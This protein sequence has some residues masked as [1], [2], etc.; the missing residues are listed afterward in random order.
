MG[1]GFGA[2]AFV[3]PATSSSRALSTSS[4]PPRTSSTTLSCLWRRAL[5]TPAIGDSDARI[6]DGRTMEDWLTSDMAES[7]DKDELA[8]LIEHVHTRVL[9]E[10]RRRKEIEAELGTVKEVRVEAG[11]LEPRR[12]RSAG[13]ALAARRPT[14]A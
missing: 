11:D 7:L 4:G 2:G 8:R 13:D 3:P 6:S 10:R 9:R 5:S 1:R 14:P 12:Q